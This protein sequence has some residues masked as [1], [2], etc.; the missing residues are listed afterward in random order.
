MGDYPD[1]EIWRYIDKE[2]P[3]DK[4]GSYA[5]QSDWG[6]HVTSIEGDYENVIGL[7]WP[8]VE[9]HLKVAGLLD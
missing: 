8:A 6:K 3:F 4:A 2:R 9:N 1:E 5:I 7:P